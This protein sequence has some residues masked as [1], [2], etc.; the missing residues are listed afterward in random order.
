IRAVDPP[1]SSVNIPRYG[2]AVILST[3]TPAADSPPGEMP[4]TA[5]VL[6]MQTADPPES[7]LDFY[8]DLLVKEGWRVTAEA[9]STPDRRRFDWSAGCPIHWM[10]VTARAGENGLTEIEVK[11]YSL[12]C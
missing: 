11:R 5:E 10:Y 7:V 1:P 2:A 4:P 9:A 6:L 12:G 3:P 8:E